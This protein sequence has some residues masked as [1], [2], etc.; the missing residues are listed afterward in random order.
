MWICAYEC[1]CPLRLEEGCRFLGTEVIDSC[2]LPDVK[3]LR[4]TLRFS[5]KTARVKGFHFHA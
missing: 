1:R 3:V 4:I 5:T 2:K